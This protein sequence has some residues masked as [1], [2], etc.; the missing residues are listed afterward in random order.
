MLALDAD[1]RYAKPPA[2][3]GRLRTTMICG[4]LAAL[5]LACAV[6]ASP[7]AGPTVDIAAAPVAAAK[8]D[9]IDI[10]KP[11]AIYALP[12]PWRAQTADYSARR[13][14][15]GG[16]QDVLTLGRLGGDEPFVRLMV[17]RIGEEPAPE[18]GFFLD[19][20]RRAADAGLAVDHSDQPTMLA[21]RFGAFEAADLVLSDARRHAACL[22][23]R[24]GAAEPALRISGFACGAGA[25]FDRV[26]LQCL[27]DRLD[28][29][30][31]GEDAPLRAFFVQAELRRRPCPVRHSEAVW[32]DAASA[33]LKLKGAMNRAH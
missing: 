28:L 24:F 26:A 11:I 31:S 23:F 14:E 18:A 19:I 29:N 15:Q 2:K 20:A 5:C 16:R 12:A 1:D 27:L 30:A 7:S 32:L 21:T 6:L 13:R 25:P 22:G 33:P 17:Y 8:R 3:R 10:V 9:W 4:A